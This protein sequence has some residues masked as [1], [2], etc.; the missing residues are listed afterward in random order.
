MRTTI[1]L[2]EVDVP[3]FEL[4]GADDGPSLSLIGG[5]HGC[6]YSSIAAVIKVMREL[7]PQQLRGSITAVPVVS[8]ESFTERSPFVV[9]ADGKNLN[10]AFPGDANGTYT[11]RLA[12]DIQTKLIV[13]ADAFIDLHGGDLVE[14]LEPFALYA[15]PASR[16]LALAM[17]LPYV[18]DYS[19]SDALQGMTVAGHGVIA[20][21]GGTGQLEPAAT[22]LLANG[23]L[24]A[25]RHLGM[26][27][28]QPDRPRSTILT[29]FEWL[30]STPAGFWVADRKTGE[31]VR[32]GDLLGDVRD[33]YGDTLQ[34]IE[35]PADGVILF[36]TTSAAVKANGLL[37]GLG[38]ES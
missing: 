17:G 23:V 7:D 22:D 25:L 33:L 37:L 19:A 5:V 28:G 18:I 21:A 31:Q 2:N 35:A 36:L 14:A 8:M 4:T 11:D 20:E 1:T 9:P 30:Y 24:N 26:L 6:E 15:N 13:P 27:P 10:R 3:A 32:Q 38:C 12:H 34:P 16:D 29:R